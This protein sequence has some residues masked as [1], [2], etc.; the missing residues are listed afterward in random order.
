MTDAFKVIVVLATLLAGA[1]AADQREPTLSWT[2]EADFGGKVRSYRQSSFDAADRQMRTACGAIQT[3]LP[4]ADGVRVTV[5]PV[6]A[7]PGDGSPFKTA[8]LTCAEVRADRN[9]L[10]A[11]IPRPQRKPQPTKPLVQ[12]WD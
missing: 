10:A 11:R 2:V 4:P 8:E 6:N 9:A 5:R 3:P 1:A 12:L 7:S